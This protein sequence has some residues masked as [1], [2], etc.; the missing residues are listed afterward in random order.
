MTMH[1]PLPKYSYVSQKRKYI[2]AAKN[3]IQ[4]WNLGKFM[5]CVYLSIQAGDKG[6][7]LEP[8]T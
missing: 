2:F 1:T 6:N 3:K 5:P 8:L 4:H 7:K